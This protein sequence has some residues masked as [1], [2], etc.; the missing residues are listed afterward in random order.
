M[1]SLVVKILSVVLLFV[2][3]TARPH[4]SSEEDFGSGE[5]F[6]YGGRN[7]GGYLGGYDRSGERYGNNGYGNGG[8]GNRGYGNG[9]YGN[10]GYGNGGYNN[11]GYRNGGINIPEYFIR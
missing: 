3:V 9:G 6:G 5:G 8:Y 7:Q 11:G 10:R 2:A 4:G 1:L